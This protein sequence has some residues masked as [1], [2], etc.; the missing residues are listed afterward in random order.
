MAHLSNVVTQ[1]SLDVTYY[2]LKSFCASLESGDD[3]FDS[4][5]ISLESG[6]D[7][8]ESDCQLCPQW[9]GL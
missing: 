3:S 1:L 2:S 4:F 5:G 7:S 9:P 6:G 8:L